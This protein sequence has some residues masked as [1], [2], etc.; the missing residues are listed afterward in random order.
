ML[1]TYV[2]EEKEIKENNRKKETKSIKFQCH[3]SNVICQMS[4]V[5]CHM[6]RKR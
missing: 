3:M 5:K 6:S 4:Y 2:E 1:T